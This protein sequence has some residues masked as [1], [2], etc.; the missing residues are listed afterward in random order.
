MVVFG[1]R[2]ERQLT[3]VFSFAT[4]SGPDLVF[5]FWVTWALKTLWSSKG[6]HRRNL[7]RLNRSARRFCIG[8]AVETQRR[9]ASRAHTDFEKDLDGSRIM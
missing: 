5:Q 2:S 4:E 7:N 1:R 8:V 6:E 3:S 9:S